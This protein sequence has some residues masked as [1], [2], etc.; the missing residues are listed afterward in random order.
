MRRNDNT[1][2]PPARPRRV[3]HYDEPIRRWANLPVTQERARELVERLMRHDDGDSKDALIELICGLMPYPPSD[4][5]HTLDERFLAG[6]AALTCAFTE[7]HRAGNEL[8]AY[9]VRLRCAAWV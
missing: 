4:D 6:L 2:T 1:A 9:V 3:P 5:K 8:G 7:T